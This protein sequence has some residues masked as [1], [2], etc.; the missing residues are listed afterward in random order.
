MVLPLF[1]DVETWALVALLVTTN[2][3]MPYRQ[4]TTEP[5]AEFTVRERGVAAWPL[6]S[7]EL[8]SSYL[9]AFVDA[10]KAMFSHG[11]QRYWDGELKRWFLSPG[12]RDQAIELA[13]HYYRCVYLVE[14]ET[15]TEL[16]SGMQYNAPKLF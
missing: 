1:A 14:G 9:P 8:D 12:A 2:K 6:L 3:P 4:K 5:Y 13:K 7:I 16:V 10:L 15:T 11:S